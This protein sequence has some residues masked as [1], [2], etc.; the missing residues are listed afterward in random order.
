[1]SDILARIGAYKREEIASAKHARPYGAVEAAAREAG[2]VRPFAGAIK[3]AIADGRTALIAEIKKA[4]PS[5]GLIRP[6]VPPACR[7]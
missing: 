1:M 6:A 3:A 2:P 7:C 5:K 4:S